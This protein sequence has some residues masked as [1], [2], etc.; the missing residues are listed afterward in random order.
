ME[1][2]YGASVR[3]TSCRGCQNRSI[4]CH[5]NCALYKIPVYTDKAKECIVRDFRIESVYRT[6]KRL[7]RVK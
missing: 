3:N 7:R 6:K 4:R 5:S 1:C 2:I